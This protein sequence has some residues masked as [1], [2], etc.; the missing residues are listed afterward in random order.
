MTSLPRRALANDQ[1]VNKSHAH[2]AALGSSGSLPAEL[3]SNIGIDTDR[4]V[5]LVRPKATDAEVG[6]DLRPLQAKLA[7]DPCN[8]RIAWLKLDFQDHFEHAVHSD[9]ITRI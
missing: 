4:V 1:L 2:A 3:L 9:G 6:I 7:P 5:V 8:R